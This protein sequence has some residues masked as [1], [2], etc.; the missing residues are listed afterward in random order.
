LGTWPTTN[1]ST[2]EAI[3]EG[4]AGTL[5]IGTGLTIYAN[6]ITTNAVAFIISG[7]TA[8]VLNGTTPTLA[9]NSQLTISSLITNSAGVIKTGTSTLILSGA[10]TTN[11]TG[12]LTVRQGTLQLQTSASAGG[13]GAIT[14]GNTTGSDAATLQAATTALTYANAI[15]LA[16][17]TTGVLMVRNTG[18]A[19]SVTFSGGVTGTNNLRIESNATTGTVTFTTAAINNIG[20]V[21]VGGAG[22]GLVTISGGIGSNVTLVDL[23]TATAC[24]SVQTT[25]L[26]VNSGGTTLR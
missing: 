17:G 2:H 13:T 7:G 19:I 23:A 3:L 5:T 6:T 20:T 11:F 4:T 22:T 18:T 12:G 9:T 16:T 10:N 21:T 14:L 8:L 25:A 26:T 24:L 1:P 15:V